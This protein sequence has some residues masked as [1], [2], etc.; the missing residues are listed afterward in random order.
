MDEPVVIFAR[1]ALARNRL[2]GEEAKRSMWRLSGRRFGLF[3]LRI[4]VAADRALVVASVELSGGIA[5]KGAQAA[6]PVFGGNGGNFVLGRRAG[7]I[8][9]DDYIAVGIP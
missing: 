6:A 8:R 5:K 9:A 4:Q 3:Q 7:S 2:P 1:A